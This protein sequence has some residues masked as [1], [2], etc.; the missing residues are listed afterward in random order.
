MMRRIIYS[1]VLTFVLTIGINGQ[2]VFQLDQ[3]EIQATNSTSLPKPV[4][5]DEPVLDSDSDFVKLFKNYFHPDNFKT[6]RSFFLPQDWGGFSEADFNNWQARINEIPLYLTDI[7]EHMDEE[8]MQYVQFIYTMKSDYYEMYQSTE[9]KWING[10][11]KHVSM[12]NDKYSVIM[13]RVGSLDRKLLNS[14][15]NS[16]NATLD[17]NSSNVRYSAVVERFDRVSLLDRISDLIF[18]YPIEENDKEYLRNLFISGDDQSFIDYLTVLT[19]FEA[20]DF[21]KEVNKRVGFRFYNITM[22]STE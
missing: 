2:T 19:N 8:G 5:H 17:L 6:Y 21:M 3:V 11:W 15:L 16:R 13:D 10:A 9:F 20:R 18:M 4:R 7:I 12:Q 1:I 22:E 14:V